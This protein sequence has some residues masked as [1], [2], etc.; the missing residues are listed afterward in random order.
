[1][2]SKLQRISELMGQMV[3]RITDN[4]HA[5][6]D[7]LIPASRLYKYPFEEQFLIYAQRPD[8]T[9]CAPLSFGTSICVG[10]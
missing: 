10:G 5:W 3:N 9:A 4:P 2:A 8:A 6:A 1:M 7:F